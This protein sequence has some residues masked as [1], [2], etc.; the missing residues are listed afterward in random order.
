MG[1]GQ[2]LLLWVFSY[3]SASFFFQKKQSFNVFYLK[4]IVI[5]KICKLFL[6]HVLFQRFLIHSDTELLPS[7]MCNI[8]YS[9]I[10][11]IREWVARAAQRLCCLTI[12]V[13]TLWWEYLKSL[14]IIWCTKPYFSKPQN[15]IWE[16]EHNQKQ[17]FWEV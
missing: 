6:N 9:L 4:K 13:P 2:F 12:Y 5:V 15:L 11:R 3:R 7:M 17:I 1:V 16:E 8:I 14:T 10:E